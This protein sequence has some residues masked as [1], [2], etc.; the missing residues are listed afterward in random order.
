MLPGT[1]VIAR[2]RDAC[3]KHHGL[4]GINGRILN[5]LK[6]YRSQT[7]VGDG[8]FFETKWIRFLWQNRQYS[9]VNAE[10]IALSASVKLLGN[11]DS[12]VIGRDSDAQTWPDRKREWGADEVSSWRVESNNWDNLR[13]NAIRFFKA[14]GWT[15]QRIK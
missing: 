10:D 3:V 15:L 2:M 5:D 1:K 8:W 9:I 4:I 13:L 11:I 6:N 12:Y 14:R 7:L